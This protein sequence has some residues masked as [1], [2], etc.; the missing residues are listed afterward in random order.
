MVTLPL[1]AGAVAYVVLVFL[2]GQRTTAELRSEIR[3]KREY[4]A[5]AESL[6]AALVAGEQELRFAREY[7][8][9]WRSHAPKW[10]QISELYGELHRLEKGSGVQTTRFDPRPVVHRESVS[11][12]PVSVDCIGSFAS[13]FTFLHSLESIP[14]EIWV[15]RIRLSSLQLDRENIQCAIDLVIFADNCD[16]LDYVKNAD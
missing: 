13:A 11:E 1:A 16:N 4:L 14:V 6:G 15:K 5:H 8:R 10:R 12:V 3:D 2:P 7:Q 9:P